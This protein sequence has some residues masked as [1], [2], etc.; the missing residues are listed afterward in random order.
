MIVWTICLWLFGVIVALFLLGV[1]LLIL[2]LIIF[3]ISYVYAKVRS[4]ENWV[5]KIMDEQIT[6]FGGIYRE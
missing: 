6:G 4:K 5:T 3:G 1:A 2:A